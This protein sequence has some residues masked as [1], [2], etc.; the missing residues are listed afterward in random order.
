[1]RPDPTI[2]L[3]R[4]YKLDEKFGTFSYLWFGNFGGSVI[5][6]A[7]SGTK[8]NMFDLDNAL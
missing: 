2:Y 1:M 8:T 5:V 6:F 4:D 7:L 3:L